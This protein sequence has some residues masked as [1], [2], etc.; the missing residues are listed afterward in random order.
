MKFVTSTFAASLVILSTIAVA[1][2]E[3]P[4]TFTELLSQ[5]TAAAVDGDWRMGES[6]SRR[7]IALPGLTPSDA[8]AG[9]SHLC[10]HLSNLG[11]FSDAFAACNKSIALEPDSWST[12]LNR[13][14]LRFAYGDKDG[15]KVDYMHARELNPSA[16]ALTAAFAFTMS[17]KYVV[18]TPAGTSAQLANVS[19]D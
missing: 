12:Y 5:S 13:G 11:K 17:P 10:M 9:F 15:A 19:A 8:A 14:N 4:A 16:P 6:Y 1:H 18:P 7:L 3:R 2:A